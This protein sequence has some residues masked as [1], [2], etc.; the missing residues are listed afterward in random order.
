MTEE[1]YFSH[2][3]Q[4]RTHQRRRQVQMKGQMPIQG[5]LLQP[6]DVPGVSVP[7]TQ[8]DFLVTAEHAKSALGASTDCLISLPLFNPFDPKEQR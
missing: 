8:T 5:L 6:G 1:P 4:Q 2:E 3:A 7:P